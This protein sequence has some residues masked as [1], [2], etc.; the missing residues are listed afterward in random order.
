V[1]FLSGEPLSMAF[2]HWMNIPLPSTCSL[3]CLRDLWFIL[4]FVSLLGVAVISFRSC[5]V[6]AHQALLSL[7][8]N[9]AHLR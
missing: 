6:P 5:G 3:I 9:L 2:F 4:L 7:L 8:R 1:K